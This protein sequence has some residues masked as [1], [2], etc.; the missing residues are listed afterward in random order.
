ISGVD[1]DP[2]VHFAGATIVEDHI[3]AGRRIIT[4]AAAGK[5]GVLYAGYEGSCHRHSLKSGARDVVSSEGPAYQRTIALVGF[6]LD[7][8]E[9]IFYLFETVGRFAV[10]REHFAGLR[11]QNYD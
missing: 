8:G 2:A 7:P 1:S 6:E 9:S 5:L 3:R 4:T 10:K 11:V